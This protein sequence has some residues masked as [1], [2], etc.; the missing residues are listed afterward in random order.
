MW[1]HV[2]LSTKSEPKRVPDL[3][4]LEA[5]QS[6]QH[7]LPNSIVEPENTDIQFQRRIE[8]CKI[9][10]WSTFDGQPNDPIQW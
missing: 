5:M 2:I 6:P 3:Q 7:V 9:Q 4:S 1:N 10:R 8:L